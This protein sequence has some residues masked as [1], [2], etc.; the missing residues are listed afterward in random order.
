MLE[1]GI[2]QQFV[3]FVLASLAGSRVAMRTN[4]S[5]SV[6]REVTLSKSIKQGCPLAPLLFIIV[7]DELH[8]GL[9][10]AK[11]G[12]VLGD[13][14]KP[15]G[16][17]VSSRG[18]CDD[19]YI[20]AHTVEDLRWL[21]QNVVHPFFEKHGLTINAIKTKVTGRLPGPEGEAFTGTVWWPGAVS[22]FETVSPNTAVKYLGAYVSL[23]LDW[24]TQVNKMQGNLYGLLSYIDSGRL[25]TLQGVAIAKYVTGPR[26]DIGM[27]HADVPLGKL[28][29][30]DARLSSS[31]ARRA[32]YASASLHM[33]SVSTVCTLTPMEDQYVLVKT[34]DSCY[35]NDH[36]QG[37]APRPL[38]RSCPADPWGNIDGDGRAQG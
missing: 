36:A 7:M 15:P 35:G 4:V 20:V 1:I 37:P 29:Q 34:A 14:D 13:P 18:Y 31:I 10:K 12:Y 28:R 17:T 32:G 11:R 2:E 26:M 30:W 38:S 19:T 23:D 22:P 25:T 27:R 3:S 5:G 9:R 24:T 16:A 33:S 8:R 6:T 21:N